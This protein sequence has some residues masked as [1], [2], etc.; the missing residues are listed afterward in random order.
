MF[1]LHQKHKITRTL[2]F[3]IIGMAVLGI[4]CLIVVLLTILIFINNDGKIEGFTD[5]KTSLFTISDTFKQFIDSTFLEGSRNKTLDVKTYKIPGLLKLNDVCVY[6]SEPKFVA[7]RNN[8]QS[9]NC[10]WWFNTDTNTSEVPSFSILGTNKEPVLYE[11]LKRRYPTGKWVWDLE[12]AQKME[13]EK[14]CKRIKICEIADMYPT[15]CG[16][17]SASNTGVSVNA[18]CANS[19]ITDV[20]NC[21]AVNGVQLCK[22]DKETGKLNINCL[23]SIA[24][25]LGFQ[26]KGVVIDILNGDNGGYTQ[27]S[28]ANANKFR[29]AKAQLSVAENISSKDAYFG[30]G[31]CSRYDAMYYYKTL[32]ALMNYSTNAKSKDAA[33]FLVN[34]GAFDECAIS[35]N[36]T[37]QFDLYCVQREALLNNYSTNGLLYPKSES[38]LT[39]FEGKTWA[40]IQQYFKS[41]TNDLHSVKFNIKR[42]AIQDIYGINVQYPELDI[43]A[44]YGELSGLSYY[45]YEWIDNE[46]SEFMGVPKLT[47]FGRQITPSFPDFDNKKNKK[48]HQC[49]KIF[50]TKSLI[51]FKCQLVT[52]HNFESKFWVYSDDGINIKVNNKSVLNR[53]IEQ[54]DPVAFESDAFAVKTP[55]T[56]E[57]NWFNS[58]AEYTFNSRMFLDNKF[59]KLPAN[60]IYQIQPTKFPIARWDFYQGTVD[61]RCDNLSSEVKG[62]VQITYL[63][64]KRCA[65]FGDKE[66][67]IR[68]NNGIHTD[69]FKTITMMVNLQKQPYGPFRF[70][71][72]RSTYFDKKGTSTCKFSLKTI[73]EINSVFDENSIKFSA[74]KNNF[75]PEISSQPNVLPLNKWTHIAWVIDEK[76]KGLTLY[77]DGVV[78]GNYSGPMQ[79]LEN[80]IYKDMYILNAEEAYDK[81][82]GVA[83]Y[84]IF[85]YSMNQT[86][87]VFDMENKYALDVAFPTDKHSGWVQP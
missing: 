23:S 77:I 38:D 58:S 53:W 27:N 2:L 64:N 74:Q 12:T 45:I 24:R 25:A 21:P 13:E 33:A 52:E 84:R 72:F 47:F 87:V 62:N 65:I 26:E 36:Y 51:R 37:G 30:L 82:I 19:I 61:D 50:S 44:S 79:T 10:G 39:K 55:T 7:P 56:L 14:L 76:N 54:V 75:G 83:W 73:I 59:Q 34:G 67:Y 3:Y 69:A 17:C 5:D 68:I 81:S 66:T 35:P 78:A 6:A 49:K 42:Q 9:L 80:Q 20:Y 48:E 18:N 85:D 22:P 15:K 16:F 4:I 60:L 1:D 70:W 46:R 29:L 31:V 71:S 28:G 11:E 43:I 8:T 86:Q 40:H 41:R 32:K 57:I 63:D